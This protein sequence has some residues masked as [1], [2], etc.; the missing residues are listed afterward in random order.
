MSEHVKDLLS[1]Y[2]DAELN[3][4]DAQ[5]VAQHIK[6]CQECWKEL[7]ELDELRGQIAFA[8]RS[9]EAPVGFVEQ[10]LADIEAPNPESGKVSA[11]KKW[12]IALVAV[13]V[14]TLLSMQMAPFLSLGAA[15]VTFVFNIGFEFLRF[16]SFVIS[17]IPY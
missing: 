6:Q 5:K 11:Y 15:M 2:L 4:P 16:I 17:K 8:Y 12:A 9:I 1:A 13:F 3:D 7:K 10:I 14:L